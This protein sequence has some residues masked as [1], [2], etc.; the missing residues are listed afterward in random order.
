MDEIDAFDQNQEKTFLTQRINRR[1]KKSVCIFSVC[2]LID[3]SWIYGI[4]KVKNDWMIF[5]EWFLT[6]MKEIN[7]ILQ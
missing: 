5:I 4:I 6:I 2:L 3:I 1:N 7:T